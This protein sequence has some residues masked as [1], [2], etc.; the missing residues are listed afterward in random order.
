MAGKGEADLGQLVEL[1]L[2]LIL[3]CWVNGRLTG[4]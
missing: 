3:Y 1:I 4:A 2:V